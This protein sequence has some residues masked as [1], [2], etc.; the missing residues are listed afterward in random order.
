MQAISFSEE[1]A[2]ADSKSEVI[3]ND[4]LLG[5]IATFMENLHLSYD[6]VVYKIPYRN[7]V[8]MQKDKLRVAYNGVLKEVSEDEF[9]KNKGFNPLK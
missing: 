1:C 2:K 7:L 8:I 5:Q 9:F 3:G 4:C 6:E